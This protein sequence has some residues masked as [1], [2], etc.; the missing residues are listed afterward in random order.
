MYRHIFNHEFNI[1]FQKPKSNQCDACE[2]VRHEEQMKLQ[3]MRSM[4]SPRM[5]PGMKETVTGPCRQLIG[6]LLLFASIS[7][8]LCHCLEPIYQASFIAGNLMSTT[9]RCTWQL[10]PR[11]LDSVH[12]GMKAWLD[13]V[14]IT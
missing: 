1:E 10:I 3:N 5:T 13:V 12:Y 4:Y 2:A 9:S 7:R 8:M 11:R 14:P 6:L